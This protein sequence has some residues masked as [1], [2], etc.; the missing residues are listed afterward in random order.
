MPTASLHEELIAAGLAS[1]KLARDTTDAMLDGLTDNQLTHRACDGGQHALHILGHLAFADAMTVGL[2]DEA[3]GTL[4]EGFSEA[5]GMGSV[6]KDHASDYPPIDVIREQFTQK[7][8]AVIA[9]LEGLDEAKLLAP[10][11]GPWA[12][13]GRNR[14]HLP[15]T[16]AW[17]EGTHSGQL[18]QIRRSLGVPHKF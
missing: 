6:I 9:W 2:D 13:F 15:H 7:R 10:L 14:A 11:E 12:E 1:L 16:L 18:S 5:F 3:A 4:P 17:H 8:A